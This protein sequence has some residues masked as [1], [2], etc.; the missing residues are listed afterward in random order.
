MTTRALLPMLAGVMTAAAATLRFAGSA[1]ATPSFCDALSPWR[2]EVQL[3]RS[4]H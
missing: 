1:P 2:C 3:A 4:L